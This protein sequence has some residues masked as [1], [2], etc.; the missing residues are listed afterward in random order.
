MIHG[1]IIKGAPQ[2][3][4]WSCSCGCADNW[5]NRTKCRQC[6]ND[7]ASWRVAKAK[8]AAKAFV[9]P[10][11]GS[12]PTRAGG[13]WADGPPGKHKDK[14]KDKEVHDVSELRG[15]ISKLTKMG[16][17]DQC[18]ALQAKLDEMLRQQREEKPISQ[19]LRAIERKITDKESTIEG[20]STRIAGLEAEV[21]RVQQKLQRE[22]EGK[23]AREAELLNLQRELED[24]TKGA[25]VAAG[26]DAASVPDDLRSLPPDISAVPDVAAA[27]EVVQ[28]AVEAARLAAKSAQDKQQAEKDADMPAG[29]QARDNTAPAP[30]GG[31]ELFE[32]CDID[33]TVE[34]LRKSDD[35]AHCCGSDGQPDRGRVRRLMEAMARGTRRKLG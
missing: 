28:K 4:H 35:L 23:A 10:K 11:P 19:T 5:A 13:A 25:K 33:A 12:R 16:L 30:A 22:R 20:Y 34:E 24:A 17:A 6:W 3:P 8:L 32:D 15:H 14:D 29:T 1:H 27:M 2:T 26:S 7:A 9:G 18:G 31:E 21:E